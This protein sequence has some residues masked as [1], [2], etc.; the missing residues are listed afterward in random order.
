[1]KIGIAGYGKMGKDIFSLLFDNLKGE[2]VVLETAGSPEDYEAAL[3]KTLDKQ[4]RRKRLT[5]EQYSAKRSAF[6]FTQDIADFAGCDAVLE[7]VTENLAL[8]QDL[9]AKIAQVVSDTCLLLT[10]TSSLPIAEVFAGIPNTER[11]LGM[12]FFYPVK[13]AEFVEL[14]LLPEN[15]EEVRKTAENLVS[16]FGRRSIPFKG[17]YHIYLNQILS[18]MISHGIYLREYFGVSVNSLSKALGEIFPV[19]GVFDLIDS[20]GLGLMAANQTRFRLQRNQALLQYGCDAMNAWLNEGCAPETR[21]FSDFIAS[22]ETYPDADCPDAPIYMTALIL[23]ETAHALDESGCDVQTLQDAVYH[24]LGIAKPLPELYREY[25]ADALLAALEQLSAK[26]SF[27]S[28]QPADK[29]L[30]EQ[31]YA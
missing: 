28:Y 2:F 21:C 19:A 6:R 3:V 18:C 22:H 8:K 15:T 29:A 9:F 30:W 24:T 26:T 27:P 25:G 16:D 14:N 23:N 11:C 13:L 4:L 5:A 17:D 7:A 20:I 31:Y 12:H 10:N 1:M